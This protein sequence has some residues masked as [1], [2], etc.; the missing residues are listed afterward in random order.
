MTADDDRIKA[1][2]ILDSHSNELVVETDDLSLDGQ[3]AEV[4]IGINHE[5]SAVTKD[6][7]IKVTFTTVLETQQLEIESFD[8]DPADPAD[9]SVATGDTLGIPNF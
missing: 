8:A 5:T 3:T 4:L 7:I 1:A 9:L 2:I 6:L